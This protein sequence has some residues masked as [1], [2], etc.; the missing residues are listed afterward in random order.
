VYYIHPYNFNGRKF[1]SG[2][3]DVSP[4]MY[5]DLPVMCSFKKIK[6]NERICS[7]TCIFCVSSFIRISSKCIWTSSKVALKMNYSEKAGTWQNSQKCNIPSLDKQA[8]GLTQ[9]PVQWVH[10]TLSPGTKGM[11]M[12]LTTH[13]HPVPRLIM[14]G[15]SPQ[16][17]LRLHG[18][19]L[20]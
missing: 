3:S 4:K 9:P 5:L 11:V 19:V 18:V 12:N 2:G 1:C 20:N 8:S 7:S 10:G 17:S 13:L 16:S 15:A 14:S 6:V